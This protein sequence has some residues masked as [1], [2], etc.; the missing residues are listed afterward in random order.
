[1][2]PRTKKRTGEEIIVYI[3]PPEELVVGD[4]SAINKRKKRG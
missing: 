1:M 4:L 2:Q 3:I